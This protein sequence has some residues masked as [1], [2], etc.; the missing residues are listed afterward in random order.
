MVSVS[1]SAEKLCPLCG[2]ELCRGPGC[3]FFWPTFN[4]ESE[5]IFLA[6]FW[7]AAS[8]YGNTALSKATAESL[9]TVEELRPEAVA[10]RIDATDQALSLLTE[11][12]ND[13]TMPQGTKLQISETLKKLE[14][15]RE[16]LHADRAFGD[17]LFAPKKRASK[18]K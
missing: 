1:E 3:M 12:N 16:S 17:K 15:Y 11:L 14:K 18:K 8:T 13:G 7:L 10:K 4:G 5:C 2:F 6:T 9:F